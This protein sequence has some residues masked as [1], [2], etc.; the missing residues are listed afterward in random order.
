[1]VDVIGADEPVPD[2]VRLL[3]AFNNGAK[4]TAL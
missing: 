4:D 1:V 3:K 2:L